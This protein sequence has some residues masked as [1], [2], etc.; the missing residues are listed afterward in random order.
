MYLNLI[1]NERD[2]GRNRERKRKEQKENG[3]K[4]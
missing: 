2:G 1:E 3:S 4:E